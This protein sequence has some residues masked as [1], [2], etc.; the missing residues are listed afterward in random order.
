[1]ANLARWDAACKEANNT[2][3]ETT[4]R[5]DNTD[6]SVKKTDAPSIYTCDCGSSAVDYYQQQT[7]G[8]DEPMTTFLH[9]NACELKWRE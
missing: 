9:C 3:N 6:S 2:V 8:A 7:R 4:A 1:M 5:A